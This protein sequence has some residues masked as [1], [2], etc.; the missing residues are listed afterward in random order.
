MLP[1]DLPPPFTVPRCFYP[2]HRP[3]SHHGRACRAERARHGSGQRCSVAGQDRGPTIPRPCDVAGDGRRPGGVIRV[4]PE[5]APGRNAPARRTRS[6][7][8]PPSSGGDRAGAGND[9]C[10][11]RRRR[12]GWSLRR[13]ERA[14][15]R[16]W[17]AEGAHA[18]FRATSCHLSSPCRRG[19]EPGCQTAFP[20]PT[21]TGPSDASKTWQG[22]GDSWLE[23]QLAGCTPFSQK[24]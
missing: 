20:T 9:R 11:S 10:R 5:P 14:G 15:L 4:R 13:Q 18:A 6:G 22:Q 1:A 12:I 17:W 16:R 8:R 3:R 19:R 2:E 21:T 7:A 24:P 23:P